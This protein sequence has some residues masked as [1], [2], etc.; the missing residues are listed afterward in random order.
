MRK[1][2]WLL[3]LSL[4]LSASS[5]TAQVTAR[6][7]T[8]EEERL[9][10]EASPLTEVPSPMVLEINLAAAKLHLRP[11]D[12]VLTNQET[13][14]FVCD[15]ATVP[16]VQIRKKRARK[17]KVLLEIAPLLRTDW[18]RQDIDLTVAF[19]AAD[20]KELGKRVWDDLTIGNDNYSMFV[21]GSQSK[22]PKLEVQLS[23]EE[24]AALYADGAGPSL[25]II[26]DIQDED[27]E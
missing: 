5:L 6:Q 25:K 10:G 20:G 18:M 19:L 1:T 23:E 14:K 15:K 21:F 7:G 16:Q 17:G 27:E 24:L 13:A 2:R 3:L 12:S 22:S 11:I 4:L 8:P 26:V 9:P